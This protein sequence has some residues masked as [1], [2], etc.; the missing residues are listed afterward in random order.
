MGI[1]IKMEIYEECLV[2]DMTVVNTLKV[3]ILKHR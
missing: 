1:I 3:G 2:S